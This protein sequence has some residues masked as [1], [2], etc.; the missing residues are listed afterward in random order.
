MVR[1]L[2][3]VK[4]L[5]FSTFPQ[6]VSKFPTLTDKE[7]KDFDDGKVDAFS[8]NFFRICFTREWVR[9]SWNF[10]AREFIVNTLFD[11]IDKEK[12]EGVFQGAPLPRRFKKREVIQKAVDHHIYYL[13]GEYKLSSGG[14]LENTKLEKRRARSRINRRK[15][16]VRFSCAVR[17]FTELV[18]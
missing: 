7:L 14:S 17:R 12:Y 4:L 10:A 1:K 13:R 2:V 6:L 18:V 8:M 9:C 3:D 16:T 11:I 15:N 5:K